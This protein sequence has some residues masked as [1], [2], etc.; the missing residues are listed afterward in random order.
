MVLEQTFRQLNYEILQIVTVLE[1]QMPKQAGLV[2]HQIP[3]HTGS[4]L[5]QTRWL[6]PEGVGALKSDRDIMNHSRL[7]PQH[8]EPVH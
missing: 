6:F 3:L 4:N 1:N 7:H 8:S 5:N 2:L